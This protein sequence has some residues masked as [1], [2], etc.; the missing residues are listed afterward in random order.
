MSKLFEL[1]IKI[2]TSNGNKKDKENIHEKMDVSEI[3][4]NT[5]TNT[6]TNNIN[7]KTN[8]IPN[9]KNGN[10]PSY[11]TMVRNNLNSSSHSDQAALAEKIVNELKKKTTGKSLV[12]FRD[13]KSRWNAFF[14]SEEARNSCIMETTIGNLSLRFEE[15]PPR[16]D[17]S[18]F[19]KKPPAI[20]STRIRLIGI[21]PEWELKDMEKALENFPFYIKDS[22]M[23]ETHTFDATLKNGNVIIYVRGIHR[24][25]HSRTFNI[26]GED[27]FLNNADRP[28]PIADEIRKKENTKGTQ[29]ENKTPTTKPQQQP[30]P[31]QQLQPQP[32]SQQ[33]QQQKT[34]KPSSSTT[35]LP[36]RANETFKK[37]SPKA[38]STKKVIESEAE[39]ETETEGETDLEKTIASKMDDEGFII[40]KSKKKRVRSPEKNKDA[41]SPQDSI[42]SWVV[43]Q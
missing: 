19:F 17:A 3:N 39:L 2:D 15:Y 35:Q 36:T 7:T 4:T 24:G 40:P 5:N 20:L 33:P 42:L 38:N 25:T 23:F 37:P 26:M 9:T 8:T 41:Q 30:Q 10:S 11:A 43:T 31:Q 1:R 16:N 12:C 34:P 22:A 29:V 14:D 28:G 18:P 21:N 6:N 13:L 27:V 32:K